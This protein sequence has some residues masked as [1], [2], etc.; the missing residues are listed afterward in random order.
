MLPDPKVSLRLAVAALMA[1]ALAAAPGALAAAP[2]AFELVTPPDK[3]SADVTDASQYLSAPQASRDGR[4]VAYDAMAGFPG[5]TSGARYEY[6][7]TRTTSG[8]QTVST[9][10]QQAVGEGINFQHYEWY[11]SDLTHAVLLSGPPSLV[12]GAPDN[13]NNLY[14]HDLG[15]GSWRLLTPLPPANWL[16]PGTFYLPMVVG[17]SGDGGDA[18]YEAPARI[19]S[20]GPDFGANAYETVDGQ[21]RAVGVRL[22]GQVD[23][24]GSAIGAGTGWGIAWGTAGNIAGAVSDDLSTIFWTSYSDGQLYVRRDGTTTDSVSSP[25]GALPDPN[26]PQGATFQ[27][28]AHDGSRALFT[29]VSALTPD[30][31]TGNDGAGTAT[32]SGANLYRYDVASKSLVDLTVTSAPADATTGAA[33]QGVLGCS[34]DARTVYVV[35]YGALAP[36]ATSGLPNLYR[37]SDDGVHPA[38]VTFIATLSDA[39]GATWSS[40][41]TG[42]QASLTADGLHLAFTTTAALGSYDNTDAVTGTPDSEVYRYDAATDRLTCASCR[43]DGA[44]PTG[45]S[46]ISIVSPF[47]LSRGFSDDGRRLFFES[48]DAIASRD[49]NGRTDVYLDENGVTSLISSGRGASDA[50]LFDTTSTGD[51]V[52]FTTREALV[53]QDQDRDVDLYDAKVGGGFAPGQGA[54][55]C[56]GDAC[57]GQASSAPPAPGI[58]TD[59]AQGLGNAQPTPPAATFAIGRLTAAQR[60]RFARTGALSLPVLVSSSGRITAEVRAVLGGSVTIVGRRS[61]WRSRP[62]LAHLALRLSPAARLTLGRRGRLTVRIVVRHSK[63]PTSRQMTLT[64]HH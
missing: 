23:P 57:Q 15:T 38:A 60:R 10:P 8:W 16:S 37:I 50:R 22:D 64:L 45:S 31:N 47:A 1:S 59:S 36:G 5:T 55:T 28:G 46:W 17:V 20:D 19:L 14:F 56:S 43:A 42:R 18:V 39:D 12:P 4:S 9:L 21:V 35:A 61:A 26:G 24:G 25:A 30:A 29:S 49:T 52:F 51:D 63:V 34:D 32:D 58:G 54:P 27:C 48:N 40:R 62:G 7:S 44:A 33:V 2:R 13:F 53:P 41:P 6:V 3:A 11:S